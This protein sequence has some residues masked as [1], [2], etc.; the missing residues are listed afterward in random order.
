M[1]KAPGPDGIPTVVIKAVIEAAS[2]DMCRI[3]MQM[4]LDKGE[5]PEKWKKQTL[6]LLSK[7]G[8]LPGDPSAYIPT[9]LL[10]TMETSETK[11]NHRATTTTMSQPE[12]VATG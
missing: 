9:C 3:A 10:K 2:P 4:Y 12:F 7:P 11:F 8:K 5:F 6:V 1:N